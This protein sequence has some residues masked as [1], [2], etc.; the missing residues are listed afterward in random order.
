MTS[1]LWTIGWIICLLSSSAW[2]I[3]LNKRKVCSLE[4]VACLATVSSQISFTK[5]VFSTVTSHCNYIYSQLIINDKKAYPSYLILIPCKERDYYILLNVYK[6]LSINYYGRYPPCSRTA[7]QINFGLIQTS[8]GNVTSYIKT[9]T[10]V[11]TP[12][13]NAWGVQ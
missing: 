4:Q 3:D 10:M 1:L 12:R 11:A 9:L 13:S 6:D 5:S 7:L 8:D 2:C